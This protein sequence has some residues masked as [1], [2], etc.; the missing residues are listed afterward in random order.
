MATQGLCRK[1][2]AQATGLKDH[3]LYVALTKPHVQAYKNR[4]LREYREN[5]AERAYVRVAELGEEAASEHVKLDANKTLLSLDKRYVAAS[6]TIHE[7]TVNHVVT[8]G[9]VID[10]GNEQQI[11]NP[12]DDR[13][14]IEEYQDDSSSRP[15]D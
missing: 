7:G 12:L 14:I 6:K 1:E 8:P 9:Y 11:A 4:V 15:T 5:T 3:S 10:L 13:G 2:A